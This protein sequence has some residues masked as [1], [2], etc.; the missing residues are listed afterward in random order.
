MRDLPGILDSCIERWQ[1]RD[2]VPI[3]DLS[4]TLVCFARSARFGDVVLKIQGPQQERLTERESLRIFAG[5]RACRMLDVDEAAAAFLMERIVP[6]TTLRAHP[7]RDDQLRIGTEMRH[8]PRLDTEE[9]VRKANE[10]IG[11]I[12]L[13]AAAGPLSAAVAEHTA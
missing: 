2:C 7:G 13:T 12:E 3:N 8:D 11:V 9:A 10:D 5:R 4:I 6:G 1:L